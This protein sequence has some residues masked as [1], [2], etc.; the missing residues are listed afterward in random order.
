MPLHP[1]PHPHN[2]TEQLFIA[3]S[4]HKNG[5]LVINV[6]ENDENIK[7]WNEKKRRRERANE[8]QTGRER[9]SAP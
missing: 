3:Y 7:K 8:T 9:S 6:V 4:S 5:E 2:L 1:H